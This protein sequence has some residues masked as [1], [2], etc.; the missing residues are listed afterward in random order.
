[1]SI[2]EPKKIDKK[3]EYERAKAE[4]IARKEKEKQEKL[5]KYQAEKELKGSKKEEQ[6]KEPKRGK[7]ALAP[8]SSALGSGALENRREIPTTTYDLLNN[9]FGDSNKARYILIVLYVAALA[10]FG[11]V[12]LIG[13][14]TRISIGSVTGNMDTLSSDKGKVLAQFGTSTGLKGVSETDLID[15][16]KAFSDATKLAVT[17]Q[18][19]VT[20]LVNEI[21]GKD[22]EGVTVASIDVSR[23][24]LKVAPGDAK[25]KDPKAMEALAKTYVLT[26][27][28]TGKDFGSIVQWSDSIRS[29]PAL[30]GVAFTRNGLKITLTA[31]AKT[32]V[33]SGAS[34]LLS[35]FGI[36]SDDGAAPTPGIATPANQGNTNQGNANQGNANQ[37]NANQGSTNNTAPSNN[38]QGNNPTPNPSPVAPG[39]KK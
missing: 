3:E 22:M 5:A 6:S 4:K 15:R 33:P 21:K 35:S 9:R 10:I 23:G 37:G 27:V 31:N 36:L 32:T 25:V 12:M 29:I 13:I 2:E 24:D 11:F 17:K 8:I 1:M 7:K 39:G 34:T 19:D 18:G 14:T 16:A 26:V 28:A 30:Y 20:S 38:T